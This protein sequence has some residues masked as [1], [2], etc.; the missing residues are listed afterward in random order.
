M[1]R[2]NVLLATFLL[3]LSIRLVPSRDFGRY[4]GEL[5]QVYTYY[6]E[7]SQVDVVVV[8][9]EFADDATVDYEFLASAVPRTE[10]RVRFGPRTTDEA[11]GNLVDGTF[12]ER[13][14]SDCSRTKACY[15]QSPGYPGVYPKNLK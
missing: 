8:A 14:F 4:C 13:V 10:L 9:E 2:T 5:D 6:A 7:N 1:K 15:V 12:C 3:Y 11:R